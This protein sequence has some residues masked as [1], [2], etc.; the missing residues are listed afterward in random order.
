MLAG[1][2]RD[3]LTQGTDVREERRAATGARRWLVLVSITSGTFMANVDAAAVTVALPTMARELDVGL[4]ALQWIVSGYFLTITAVLPLFGRLADLVG[5]RRVL[6]TGLVLFVVAS[7]LV[8]LS[9]SFPTLIAARALQGVGAS[10]FMATIMASAVTAFPPGER[11]RVLGL[12]TSVVAAGTVVGPGLGGVLTDAFGWRSIFVV[13]VPVGLLG[14]AGIFVLLPADRPAGP[15]AGRFTAGFD[16][17]G[18]LLFAGF[19]SAL[20]LGLGT[21]P[22]AGWS[23]PT[24]L[25]LLGAS[26]V[27]LLLFA[28]QES[29]SASPVIDLRLF[30]RR[31]FGLGNLAGFVAFV[32][33]LF[34]AVLFPLYLVEVLHRSLATAGMLMSLQAATMLL[35]SP[36]AGRWSD[37][38]GSR[39]PTLV[40]LA[41][42]AAAMLASTLLGRGTP[43]W[44]VGLVLA[45]L[46]AGSG[47][48]L[49]PN[50][51]AVMGDLARDR[52]GT[53]G[54]I[55]ATARNL[56]KAVGVAVAVLL[57]TAFAGTSA[58]AGVE[59]AVL[60]AGFRGAFLV[61]AVLAGAGLL[62]V[63][64]MYRGQGTGTGIGTTYPTRQPPPAGRRGA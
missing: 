52:A 36:A 43:L 12:L 54:A 53:A 37:R 50:N 29:R 14:A 51:S 23:S 8:A 47:L 24:T 30:R 22:G 57:Y 10:M 1:P 21:G 17:V 5:R 59:A 48:F 55:L 4:D 56:G 27:F 62:A 38:A 25:G 61:G 44:L 45:L 28:V 2:D 26:V 39:R 64:L 58:T 15:S 42:T 63:V 40:G 31:V 34:P 46:G 3:R 19:S 16:M 9:P 49:S 20:I 11:G 6:S 32:L 41:L 35:I 60:L 13:N 33:L 18:A 7:L